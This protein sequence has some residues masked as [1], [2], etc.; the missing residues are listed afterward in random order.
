MYTIFSKYDA[1]ANI[2]LWKNDYLV[3]IIIINKKI[4]NTLSVSP[5]LRQFIESSDSDEFHETTSDFPQHSNSNPNDWSDTKIKLV[6]AQADLEASKRLIK[7]E[8][9]QW[10]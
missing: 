3:D 9:Y 7:L 5:K 1:F 2:N 10:Q 4:P 8:N 6:V